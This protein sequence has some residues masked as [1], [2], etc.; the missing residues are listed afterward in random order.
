M[1]IEKIDQKLQREFAKKRLAD[2]QR[3]SQNLLKANSVPAYRELSNLEREI[4][5]SLAKEK[6]QAK[7]NKIEIKGMEEA[8]KKARE[9]KNKI[10]CKLGLKACDLEPQY[11]CKNCK[12]TGFVGEK[13][14]ICYIKRRNQEIV[15]ACGLQSSADVTFDKF[16]ESV[17]KDDVQQK[18]T[19]KLKD[20]LCDWCNK[21]PNISKSN[22]IISGGTGVG[23]TF[24]SKCMANALLKKDV[25]VC[26]V[27]A[28]EMNDMFLKYHTTFNSSK[29]SVLLPL[30]E[31]EVLFIDDLGTE[32][33]LNNVTLNYLYMV[34]SERDR[35]ERAT[36]ITTNLLPE[37]IMNTYGE[38]IFSRL[39]N[40]R[41]SAVFKL[42]GNDLRLK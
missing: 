35:F 20:K 36:I 23:K 19:T 8:L 41:T 42:S 21:Y 32:P 24:L 2:E 4:V 12:D 11:E 6:A 33:I 28:N 18:Q 27:T 3:V 26:F 13:P 14:C 39:M 38:R 29:M 25:G 10:L 31:S 34:I 7:P 16:D 37:D 22:I 9:E 40:K 5:F 1:D 30:T 17:F 15:K